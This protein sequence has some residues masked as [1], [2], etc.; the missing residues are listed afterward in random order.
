[1]WPSSSKN[2]NVL[3]SQWHCADCHKITAR[4]QGNAQNANVQVFC[5]FG[6]NGRYVMNFAFSVFMAQQQ[7]RKITRLEKVYDSNTT[8]IWPKV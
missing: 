2:Q 6:N 7:N 5:L 4:N 3:H 8:I 1:M